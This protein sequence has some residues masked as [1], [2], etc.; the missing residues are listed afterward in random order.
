MKLR[1]RPRLRALLLRSP[2]FALLNHVLHPSPDLRRVSLR[3]F[4]SSTI[5]ASSRAG[6]VPSSTAGINRQAP[7]QSANSQEMAWANGLQQY[8]NVVHRL[9]S[10]QFHHRT[11]CAGETWEER[12]AKE[13][14]PRSPDSDQ[15]TLKW[16]RVSVLSVWLRMQNG[17]MVSSW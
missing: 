1:G 12:S 17:T 15:T 2:C 11:S 3:F 6:I 10:K 8:D 7:K 4:A 9:M 13:M 14:H 16:Q 5:R